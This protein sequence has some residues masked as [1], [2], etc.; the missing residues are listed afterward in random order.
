MAARGHRQR[1]PAATGAMDIPTV[2]G[3]GTR[4]NIP[5]G[6]KELAMR[7]GAQYRAGGWFAPPGTDLGPF[8]E[9]G[10]GDPGA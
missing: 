6:N 8:L 9:K 2:T 7:L 4:L 5:F 3:N 1:K 10:W